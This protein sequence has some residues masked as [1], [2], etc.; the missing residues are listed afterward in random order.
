MIIAKLLCMYVCMYVH[1][2]QTNEMLL[3]SVQD[4]GHVC[5]ELAA[6]PWNEDSLPLTRKQ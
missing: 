2:M 6:H 4:L 5:M 3:I 1:T